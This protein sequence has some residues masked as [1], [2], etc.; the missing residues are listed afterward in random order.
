[1]REKTGPDA[2]KWWSSIVSRVAF[3]CD[4]ETS[5]T[6]SLIIYYTDGTNGSVSAE[7]LSSQW[8]PVAPETVTDSESGSFARGS[9]NEHAFERDSAVDLVARSAR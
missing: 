9:R 4:A 8:E 3:D 5:R 2:N 1:M 6:E 7:G